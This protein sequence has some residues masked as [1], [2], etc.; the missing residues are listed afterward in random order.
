MK[1]TLT[2]AAAALALVFLSA[3]AKGFQ[4]A[5][6]PQPTGKPTQIE[7]K[8]DEVMKKM[9]AFLAN[10][11]TFSLEAEE[12]FDAEFARAYRIQLT[13]VR[14]I[15]VERPSRF[16]AVAKGDT[17]HRASWYDGKSLTVR[18]RSTPSSTSWR[19]TTSSSCPCRTSST[20]TRIPR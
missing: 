4:A 12:T 7:A 6:A 13:N 3:G 14:T 15:T 9:S 11:K 18:A 5:P 2:A 20:A 19:G 1:R 10:T 16:A 17:A 8:A